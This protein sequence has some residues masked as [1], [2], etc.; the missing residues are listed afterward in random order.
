[1]R[2]TALSFAAVTAL[3]SIL[4]GC[5]GG[6]EKREYA[7]PDTLC[8]IAVDPEAFAPLFPPGKTL[9]VTEK[10]YATATSC[11]IVVDK[12][13]FATTTRTWLEEGRTTAYFATSLSLDPPKR[14][15][16]ADRYRYSDREAFAKTQKCVD[17]QHK[18]ELYTAVQ[19]WD[20]TYKDADAMKRLIS[21]F[22]T[23][24]EKSAACTAGVEE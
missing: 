19:I 22:T 23:E 5:G 8:G 21:S 15:A 10:D 11:N 18:Q 1:M 7:I 12:K 4:T 14:S 3:L 17:S 9:T 16:E 24:V 6:E 20:K 2:R 13:S